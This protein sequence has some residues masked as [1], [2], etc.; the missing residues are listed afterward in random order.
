M[1]VGGDISKVVS[2]GQT[3]ADRGGLEW[4][5]SRGIAH[6]GWCPRGRKAED[7]RVPDRYLLAETRSGSYRKRTELNVRYSDGTVIFTGGAKL[8]GGSLL[9]AKLAEK[10]GRPWVHLCMDGGYEAAGAALRLFVIENSVRVL[11]VAG[12]RES[13]CAGI[14]LFAQQ[15]LDEAFPPGYSAL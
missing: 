8:Q 3:G 11:N 13:R 4:A 15:A 7:G 10:H 9:T 14:Q 1:S 6:G 5:I 12:N 2:G